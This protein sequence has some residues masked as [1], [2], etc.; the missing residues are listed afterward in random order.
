MSELLKTIATKDDIL[1][2]KDSILSSLKDLR[3]DMRKSRKKIIWPMFFF[4]LAQVIANG[5]IFYFFLKR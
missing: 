4:A 2:L 1:A 5:F 3:A